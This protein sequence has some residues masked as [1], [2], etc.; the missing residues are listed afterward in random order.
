MNLES[1]RMAHTAAQGVFLTFR[2]RPTVRQGLAFADDL[3]SGSQDLWQ[4]DGAVTGYRF[5]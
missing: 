5:R 4:V 1:D 3:T 2:G